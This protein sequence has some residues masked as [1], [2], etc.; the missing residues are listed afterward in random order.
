MVVVVRQSSIVERASFEAGEPVQIQAVLS[1]LAVEAF[2]E[3]VLCR[4]SWLDEV[5][6]DAGRFD[7]K[8]I[9]LLVSSGPLSMTIVFGNGRRP[10]RVGRA[11]APGAGRRSR[12]RRS[13]GRTPG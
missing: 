12:N 4:L 1:E 8:N 7:Q 10:A 2:H 3:C 9:A 13:A 5:Q 6:L 11:R